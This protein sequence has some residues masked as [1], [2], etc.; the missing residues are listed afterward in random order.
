MKQPE[1]KVYF[2]CLYKHEILNAIR[3][4]YESD[5]WTITDNNKIANTLTGEVLPFLIRIK[6]GNYQLGKIIYK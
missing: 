5:S 1:F 6:N 4:Y 2:H 3:D